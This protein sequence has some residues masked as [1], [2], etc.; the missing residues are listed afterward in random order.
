MAHSGARRG[1]LRRADKCFQDNGLRRLRHVGPA[2]TRRRPGLEATGSRTGS[3]PRCGPAPTATGHRGSGVPDA[4][5]KPPARWSCPI[6]PSP[7]ATATPAQTAGVRPAP[8]ALR[9]RTPPSR[10]GAA[11]AGVTGEHMQVVVPHILVAG[12]PVVLPGR[13]AFAAEDNA[14]R[15]RQPPRGPEDLHTQIVG[16][17]EYVLMMASRNHQAVAA[18]PRLVVQRHE[19]EHIGIDQHNGRL[20]IRRRKHRRNGAE[21]ARIAGWCVLHQAHSSRRPT[22]RSAPASS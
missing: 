1:R 6:L 14:H 18:D 5:P 16:N 12:R 9:W 15:L 8:C 11:H 21:R 20:R 10:P 7:T 19:R 13:D 17:V 4:D 2:Q 3:P 22:S